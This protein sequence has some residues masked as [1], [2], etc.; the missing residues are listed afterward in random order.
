M[1]LVYEGP[2]HMADLLHSVLSESGIRSC[3]S[4]ESSLSGL[5]DPTHR[6]AYAGLPRASVYV[7]EADT[8]LAFRTVEECLLLVTTAPERSTANCS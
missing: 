4:P 5:L 7:W 3:L 6:L 1:T 8:D 2:A